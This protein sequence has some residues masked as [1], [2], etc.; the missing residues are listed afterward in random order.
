M[1]RIRLSGAFN[2]SDRDGPPWT[3]NTETHGDQRIASRVQH[4]VRA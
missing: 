3:L 4:F 2:G 1:H